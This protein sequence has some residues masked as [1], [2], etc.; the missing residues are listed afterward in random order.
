MSKL[1]PQPASPGSNPGNEQGTARRPRRALALAAGLCLLGIFLLV[2]VLP[3]AAGSVAS[4]A[5][6]P[7]APAGRAFNAPAGFKAD[8]LSAAGQAAPLAP[9]AKILIGDYV[10][11]DAAGLGQHVGPE[12]EYV[13]GINGVKLSLYLDNND[14]VFNPLTDT[15]KL[16]TTTS[17][18][19]PGPGTPANV[20]KGWYNFQ[21]PILPTD[22]HYWVVVDASNFLPGGPLFGYALTSGSTYGPSPMMV[23][24]PVIN[25]Q[26]YLDADFGYIQLGTPTATATATA[27]P[28]TTN[29]PLP[30][31]IDG[32][33]TN[34]LSQGLP[35]WIIK[36]QPVGGGTIQQQ[37]T[38]SQ[39]YLSS[40]T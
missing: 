16:T 9:D 2:I 29:T 32:Y 21:A 11:Y 31:C 14:G 12:Q 19:A 10:W 37:T 26:D 35:G 24:I 39:G 23:T 4:A 3:Q 15:L 8:N 17:F 34:D 25:P 38:S 27:T 1:T 28:T 6:R 7:L 20:D 40:T 22:A 5:N 18:K 13:A 33:K 36:L 30:G